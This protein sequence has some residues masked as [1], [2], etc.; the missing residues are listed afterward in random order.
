MMDNCPSHVSRYTKAA[1][2][3]K[4]PRL[5]LYPWPASSPD[6]SA[7]DFGVFPSI[8]QLAPELRTSTSDG[9]LRAKNIAAF[10][11][12]K[13]G[14]HLIQKSFP[15]R[16]RACLKAQGGIFEESSLLRKAEG[17]TVV[18]FFDLTMLR[19]GGI[20][21]LQFWS[22]LNDRAYACQGSKIHASAS[23]MVPSYFIGYRTLSVGPTTESWPWYH[24]SL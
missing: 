7:L 23:N 18:D 5:H 10:S 9:D 19:L 11:R 8:L 3:A 24:A 6:L 21:P 20:W 22:R 1:L 14:E 16:L 17:D 2:A 4:W 12:Y 15:A 13:L